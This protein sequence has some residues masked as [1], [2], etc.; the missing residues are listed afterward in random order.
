MS[1]RTRLVVDEERWYREEGFRARK[2]NTC[3]GSDD[4][5][6]DDCLT[7]TPVSDTHRTEE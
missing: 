3:G 4:R 1:F 6:M 7:L 2:L 5:V